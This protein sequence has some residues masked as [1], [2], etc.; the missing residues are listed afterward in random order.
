MHIYLFKQKDH[1]SF[2]SQTAFNWSVAS[3]LLEATVSGLGAGTTS[4]TAAGVL[5]REKVEAGKPPTFKQKK[6]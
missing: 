5:P 6:I 3:R 2:T 1:F 4:D